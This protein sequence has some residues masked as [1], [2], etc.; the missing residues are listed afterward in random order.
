M[1]H[2]KS[3][4]IQVHMNDVHICVLNLGQ[5]CTNL[6]ALVYEHGYNKGMLN[7]LHM[8]EQE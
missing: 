5:I 3:L 7:I 4:S 6:K 8:I 1:D 2:P